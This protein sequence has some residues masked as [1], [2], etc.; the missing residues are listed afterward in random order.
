[1]PADNSRKPSLPPDL[2]RSS[3]TG[4]PDLHRTSSQMPVT[5]QAS[6]TPF[7]SACNAIPYAKHASRHILTALWSSAAPQV[8]FHVEGVAESPAHESTLADQHLQAGAVTSGS[9]SPVT[10]PPT[11]QVLQ[12][13]VHQGEVQVPNDCHRRPHARLDPRHRLHIGILAYC[14]VRHLLSSLSGVESDKFFSIGVSHPCIVP[15]TGHHY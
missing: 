4:P 12:C 9:P 10:I 11:F 6:L 8:G 7:L 1:M 14:I 15:P 5:R 3:V 2:R 13:Q